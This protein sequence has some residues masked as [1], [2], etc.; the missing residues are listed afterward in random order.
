MKLNNQ[1]STIVALSG[2]LFSFNVF[3]FDDTSTNQTLIVTA[4]LEDSNVLELANSV[5]VID[6][7]IIQARN[8]QHLSDVL[9]LAPNVNFATGA[10]RGRFIQIRGI[11]ERSEFKEPVN[12]S[13][14]VVLDGIDLTGISTAATTLDIQQIE[15]LRGP[16]GTLYGA[17]GL[18]G[19]IN[20]VSNSPTDVF[21]SKLSA[22]VESFGGRELSGVV[23]GPLSENSGYRFALKQNLSDGFMQND[24]LNRDDTNNIDE[25]SLRG[26]IVS[27]LN[28]VLELTTSVFI[29]DIDNGYDAFSLDS[30]RN[31]LSDQ[32]GFD[33][34]KTKAIAI[35]LDW[36]INNSVWLESVLSY[37]DSDLDY[38]YDEDWSHTGICDGTPCDSELAGFDWWYSSFDH[39]QR[40]NDNLS[41]D[42]KLH[43]KDTKSTQL[44][45]SWVAGFYFRDQ[46]VDLTRQYT[47]QAE[48][49]TSRL[50]SKNMALFGQLE[51]PL[52]DQLTL[53]SGLRFER[54][55]T[56]YFDNEGATFSPD[57]NLWGGKLSIEYQYAPAKM[58]YGLVSRGY[59]NGGFNT[60]GSIAAEN[61]IYD[62]EFMWNYEAGIK[63]LWLDDRLTL[64]AAVFYQDRK[65]IQTK[66]SIVRSIDSG[67]QIQENGE[68]PCSFTDLINNAAS[69]SSVGLEIE[70]RLQATD[71]LQLY[72]TVGLL[73]AEFDKYLSYTHVDADLE[74]VPPVPVDMS[75]R[76]VA[77]A[78]NYQLLIGGIYYFNDY[79]SF[80]PELESKRD[81]YFSDRH[82]V[83]SDSY[84]LVNLR[85][86]YQQT[87]WRVSLYVDN[88]FDKDIQTRGFGS[89]GN[90]PRNFYARGEYFQFAAPRVV[91]LSFSHEFE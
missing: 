40:D 79:F 29:A 46:R 71:N 51:T 37:A 5:S 50:D 20:L 62:T 19:L 15:I 25:F 45:S 41:L 90:D 88:V 61:R 59:K 80:N 32:P 30:N 18:A 42:V 57:E 65:D 77:H 44:T 86:V 9:N 11:G 68:C 22:S 10:S 1:Y 52:A 6:A 83:N 43:S 12:Y 39:Y 53:V 21:Y 34:Q 81:F 60:D 70:T 7:E 87:D 64:Q 73:N 3:A 31:T 49:F 28:E 16:Q 14:G 76:D 56:N 74:A 75:G 82:N 47:Y 72:S 85:L 78:P 13:V 35:D 17:N 8:S 58:I 69:G 23:S 54:R 4:E 55:S 84:Q 38:A 27:E 67:L 2:C 91:G 89:F 26:K 66:Q 33:R 48:D 63:G 36:D 24:F